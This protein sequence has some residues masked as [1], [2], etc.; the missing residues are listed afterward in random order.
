MKKSVSEAEQRVGQ[1]SEQLREEISKRE[2][3]EAEK[4]EWERRG[5]DYEEV[6]RNVREVAKKEEK[7]VS[8]CILLELD[9]EDF[10]PVLKMNYEAILIIN[11]ASGH[12]VTYR[13]G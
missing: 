3:A 8:P 1:S 12:D 9:I 10:L 13:G 6:L 2:Y 5:R 4:A 11:L 7:D